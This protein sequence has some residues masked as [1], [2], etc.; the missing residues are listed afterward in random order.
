MKKLRSASPIMDLVVT[1]VIFVMLVGG[2]A[3]ELLKRGL[4]WISK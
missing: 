2:I 3:F 1:P 4:I